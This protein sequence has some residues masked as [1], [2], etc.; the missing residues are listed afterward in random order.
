MERG[1]GRGGGGLY[2]IGSILMMCTLLKKGRLH[3]ERVRRR[4]K[5]GEKRERDTDP[6]Q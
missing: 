2:T 3:L 5:R 4:E 6:Y 1:R